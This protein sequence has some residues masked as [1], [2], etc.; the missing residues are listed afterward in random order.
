MVPNLFWVRWKCFFLSVCLGLVLQ[1]SATTTPRQQLLLSITEAITNG[2]LFNSCNYKF[3]NPKSL[4]G[5]LAAPPCFIT[6]AVNIHGL[7]LSSNSIEPVLNP[8]ARNHEPSH[9]QAADITTSC[10]AAVMAVR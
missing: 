7:Q 10:G 4:S 5:L 9:A 1:L 8:A 6:D 3:L 2:S